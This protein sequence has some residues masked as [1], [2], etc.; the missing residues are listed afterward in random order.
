MPIGWPS[1]GSGAAPS[2]ADA[3]AS[4]WMFFFHHTPSD[5]DW[6]RI[7]GWLITA[8]ATVF[9]APFWFDALQQIVRLKGSGPS[10]AEKGTNAAAGK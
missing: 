8:F 6:T 9:G 7:G 5:W 10:P 1:A 3:S 2:A 4:A